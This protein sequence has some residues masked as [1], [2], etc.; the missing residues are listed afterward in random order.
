M[1]WD[2]YAV[3]PEIDPRTS[4][5]EFLTAALLEVFHRASQELARITGRCSDN[6]GTGILGGLSSGIITRATG[7]SDF[8]ETSKD[9]WLLW[10]PETVRL[11]HKQAHWDFQLPDD[12]HSFLVT[13]ARLFLDICAAEGLAIW[14]DW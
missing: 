13:E 5:G 12:D 4:D 6:L 10:S 14:F 3:I 8:D 1:G 11:A 9:G 7:V 2:A